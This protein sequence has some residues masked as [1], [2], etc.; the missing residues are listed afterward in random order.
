MAFPFIFESNF[1]IGDTTEWDSE[2]DTVS[3][4]DIAHFTELCRFPWPTAI[5]FLGAYCMRLTLSGGTAD[6]FLTEGDLNVSLAGNS[7]FRFMI[8][9]DPDFTA[10][11]DD[12]INIF[13]LQ[14]VGN[15]VEATFGLRIVAATGAI[16]FGIGEVAPTSFGAEAITRGRWYTIELDVTPD[17]GASN[18]GTIDLYVTPEGGKAA[19]AVHATQVGSLDQGAV[20][21]GVLG[22]QGQLAT[23]LGTI[24]IDQFI[25]DDAR[26][27]PITDRFKESVLMTKSGHVFLGVGDIDNVSLLSGAAT[28]CVLSVYDTDTADTT[29]ASNVLIELKNT[30]NNEV[31]D[32]AGTP[33]DVTKGAFVSLTGTNPRGI[34][35][36]KSVS[37]F[38]SIGAIRN[39]G[40]S[41]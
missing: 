7:F 30:A 9:I 24:L 18:N 21:H 15:V 34:V 33:V 37:A 5:P 41:S 32:P 38:G 28:D 25:Q 20:T 36:L 10:T 23:S 11:A 3:Q 22:V 31:V 6:A 26:I 19:T 16:N 4:L 13:E 14:D 12:T 8:W 35:K 2:T 17:D 1:E 27:Y 40:R 39:L 29:D